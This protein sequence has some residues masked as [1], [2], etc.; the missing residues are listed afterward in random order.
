MQSEKNHCN[1]ISTG[2]AE[3]LDPELDP[4]IRCGHLTGKTQKGARGMVNGSEGP[5]VNCDG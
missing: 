1:M 4:F 2:T 5:M 3:A